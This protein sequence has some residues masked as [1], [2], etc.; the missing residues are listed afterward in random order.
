MNLA[1]I[2]PRN[3]L[4]AIWSRRH[5]LLSLVRMDL[6]LRYRRS[7]LGVVW[8]LLNPLL[9][10]A[11]LCF[12]FAGILNRSLSDFAPFVLIGLAFWQFLQ[13]A[14]LTGC[15]SLLQAEPYI[16]QYPAP[17]AL[18]SLRVTLGAMTHH[19]IA[20]GMAIVLALWFRGNPNPAALLALLPAAA[21]I[22][23]LGWA[24]ATVTGF[25]NAHF[26]DT[27]HLLETGLQFLYF[28][29]PIL[30][31]PADFV[32]SSP[33]FARVLELNPVG[34]FARLLRDPILSG[35]PAP[36]WVW[37]G[38]AVATAATASLAVALLRRWERTLVFKL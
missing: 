37:L 29:T 7:A 27:S 9:M 36:G 17:L 19:L 8:S 16:R 3:Y 35:A 11:V 22:V 34:W 13:N 2:G 5:F 32:K 12:G 6:R 26:P 21:L 14:A 18:Y 33:G 10:T 31:D 23:V 15:H 28:L 38:A 30:F 20:L 25:F 1:D 4:A 24:I